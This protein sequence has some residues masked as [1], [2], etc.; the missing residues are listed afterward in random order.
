MVNMKMF[1]FKFLQNR[2]M[3]EK[4]NFW[5]VMG[6]F[7]NFLDFKNSEKPRKE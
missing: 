3:N 7:K 2:T 1:D 5:E 4:F 6:N